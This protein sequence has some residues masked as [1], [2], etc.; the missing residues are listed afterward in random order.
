[1]CCLNYLGRLQ[2]QFQE[3]MACVILNSFVLKEKKISKIPPE[4]YERKLPNAE[5]YSDVGL[6]GNVA[7]EYSF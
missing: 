6:K 2:K 4:Y 5:Q 7:C 1:M 3:K